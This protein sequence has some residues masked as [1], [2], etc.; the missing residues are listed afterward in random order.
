MLATLEKDITDILTQHG[1]IYNVVN[2]YD[3][4]TRRNQNVQFTATKEFKQAVADIAEFL[5]E[6]ITGTQE[7]DEFQKELA[8][9]Q[10]PYRPHPY[11]NR[12]QFDYYELNQTEAYDNILQLAEK[13]KQDYQNTK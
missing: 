11:G 2:V 3:A 4:I 5:K 8:I 10:Y 12:N 6:H 1:G 7:E 13:M 9:M